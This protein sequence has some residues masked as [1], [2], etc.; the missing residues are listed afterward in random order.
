MTTDGESSTVSYRMLHSQ[1]HMKAKYFKNQFSMSNSKQQMCLYI[2]KIQF[3]ANETQCAAKWYIFVSIWINR[4]KFA[5]FW[6]N[7]VGIVLNR[8]QRVS[9]GFVNVRRLRTWGRFVRRSM[10]NANVHCETFK[11]MEVFQKA[12]NQVPYE[13]KPRDMERQFCTCKLLILR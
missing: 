9:T 1:R 6:P 10:S 12:E 7:L 5:V 13:L 2:E 8:I 11:S 4:L 3:S